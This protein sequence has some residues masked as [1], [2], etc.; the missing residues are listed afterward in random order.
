MADAA[1]VGAL[2]AGDHACLTFS[3]LDERWDLVAAFV[4]DGLRRGEKVV[5]W[6]DSLPP[7]ALARQLTARAVRPGAALR[8]GQ[9]TIVAAD[10][11]LLSGREVSSATMLSA[12][13][14]ELD[15]ATRDG[16]PGLRVAADMS[17]A[18]RPTAA[19]DQL[20]A[21]EAEVAPLFAHGRLCVICEYDR[22]SFDAITLAFA[23]QAH[24]KTVAALVYHDHPLLRV[25]RQ[26]SPPGIRVAGELD[27]RHK[28]VLEQALAESVRLDR[29]MHVNLA[30]LDYIDAACA[31]I[32]VQTALRLPPSRRMSITCRS[33]VGTV[34]DLVG[35][36]AAPRLRVQ[37]THDQP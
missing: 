36:S 26:Y 37:R 17:W 15:R 6:T 33:L 4:R 1:T 27:Y 21:F 9:L 20:V 11:A 12:L 32:I 23:A 13:G 3:D 10:A 29:H 14:G 28:D 18:T 7:D 25:C 19:A 8:R 24:P 30:G 2:G 5:C 31:A 22:D 34:L 16:Y 35:A